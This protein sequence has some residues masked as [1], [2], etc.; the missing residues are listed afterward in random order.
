MTNVV[1]LCERAEES[2]ASR[3]PSQ[4]D[5]PSAM[6]CYPRQHSSHRIARLLPRRQSPRGIAGSCPERLPHGRV[7]QR[8]RQHRTEIG[9]VTRTGEESRLTHD[10]RNLPGSRTHHR[11]PMR[12]RVGNGVTMYV[13]LRVARR[14]GRLP[15]Y[16]VSSARSSSSTSPDD[17]RR[18]TS[19]CASAPA[20]WLSV[21]RFLV[22]DA[23]QR[24]TDISIGASACNR[25][26][27]PLP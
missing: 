12:N 3:R 25:M 5:S 27:Y 10:R 23:G 8:L 7:R 17:A 15:A 6:L 24:P 22:A 26:W 21:A 4:R 13:S 9:N 1:R 2:A 11:H 19:S 18:Y 14:T 16:A 20:V